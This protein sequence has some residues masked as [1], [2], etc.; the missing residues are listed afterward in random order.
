ALGGSVITIVLNAI[1]IPKYSYMGSAWAHLS[2][3]T[4][5]MVVSYL[6]GRKYMPIPY[7]VKRV[8]LYIGLALGLYFLNAQMTIWVPDYKYLISTVLLLGFVAFI[9]YQLKLIKL[10]FGR[11]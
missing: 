4:A 3:Y 11:D 6:W 9:N 10:F 1:L 8:L 2:C 5:M 7:H